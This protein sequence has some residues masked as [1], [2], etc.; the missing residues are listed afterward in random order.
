MELTMNRYISGAAIGFMMGALVLHPF[1]MLFQGLVHPEPSFDIRGVLSAFDIHHFP[2]AVFFG[3]LGALFGAVNIFYTVRLTKEK[4]KVRMLEGLL[5]ICAYC[6]KIRDDGAD[7]D[8]EAGWHEIDRYISRR[9]DATFTHGMCPDCF[10][11]VMDE[12]DGEDCAEGDGEHCGA[13]GC[14]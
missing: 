13:A 6:K 8:V 1:S 4:K 14:R 12:L 2:M 3:A 7:M 5:P 9:T 10:G 11:R